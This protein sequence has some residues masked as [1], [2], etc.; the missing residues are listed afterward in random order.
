MYFEISPRIKRVIIA[1]LLDVDDAHTH[2]RPPLTTQSLAIASERDL[3]GLLCL[4]IDAAWGFSLD[5]I[6]KDAR[7]A[8]TPLFL[9]LL[10]RLPLVSLQ[11]HSSNELSRYTGGISTGF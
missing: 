11:I 10:Q 9:M 6:G 1:A 5:V 8:F 2:H 3:A 4:T 7:A